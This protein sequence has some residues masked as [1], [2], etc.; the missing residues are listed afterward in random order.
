[1]DKSIFC[2]NLAE[3]NILNKILPPFFFALKIAC[4]KTISV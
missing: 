4:P 2:H 3:A 1:M